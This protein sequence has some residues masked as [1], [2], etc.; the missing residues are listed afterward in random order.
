MKISTFNKYHNLARRSTARASGLDATTTEVA[1]LVARAFARPPPPDQQQPPPGG[2][3]GPDGEAV[4]DDGQYGGSS[5]M[6][7]PG[8]LSHMLRMFGMDG[9]KI[10][11][12]AVN[13]IIFIAQM[14]SES[15]YLLGLYV[16]Q[17]LWDWWV[18]AEYIVRRVRDA[19][20]PPT[21]DTYGVGV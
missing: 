14:V 16:Q 19:Q 1:D 12:M 3:F 15:M 18:I 6:A 4:A 5:N 20:R 10:G 21:V 8:L 7:P 17:N 9:G 13:G 2:R 11:A